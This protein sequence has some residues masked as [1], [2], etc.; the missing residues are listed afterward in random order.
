LRLH[1]SYCDAG[2]LNYQQNEFFSDE[3]LNIKVL[4]FMMQNKGV[5]ESEFTIRRL[6][7][8]VEPVK[9]QTRCLDVLEHFI[10]NESLS[11]IAIVD[12]KNKPLGLME[13]GRITE[14]FLKPF[15][16]D[17]FHKK[18]IDEIMDPEP[19]IV[20]IDSS[21]EDVVN[22]IINSGMHHMVNGVIVLEKGLYAG[23]ATGHAL[24]E[25][26]S[27]RRQ[28]D[29]YL[30]AHY[31]HLTGLP[32]RMLFNDRLLQACQNAKRNQKMLA[33]V[34]IDLDRFKFINDSMGHSFGDQIL[35]MVSE[36]LLACVRQSD[37][38]ARLG[39]DEFVM[40]LQNIW[41]E[42]DAALLIAEINHRMR[43]PMPV[44]GREIQITVSMGLAFYPQHDEN[45]DG[46]I[47]K[48]DA[49]MY[50][51]KERGRNDF[52]IFSEHMDQ[53]NMQRMSLE[54]QLRMALEGNEFF[55]CYQPQIKLPEKKII[56]VEALLRWSHPK[57]GMVSPGQFI[58]IAEETGLIV[59]IGEWVLREACRQHLHWRQQGMPPIRIA[60]NISAVQ[61]KQQ[62][63]C[64]MVNKILE[65][66]GMEPKYLELELTESAVMSNAEHAVQA[67]ADL[68]DLGVKLAIDDFGTGY[69]SLSY[70]RKFPIDRIKIDQSFIHQIHATSANEAIVRAIIALADSL[71]LET[72]AEGVEILEDLEC[73]QRYN[74]LEVQGY[75][76]A[77]PLDKHQF[78]V[79]CK[80]CFNP[81]Q[82][83]GKVS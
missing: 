69:S 22:I 15:A 70:L 19:I 60:V 26:I 34:F 1:N 5:D 36:R 76:F 31:D 27:Q 33:L 79:W 7:G 54:T 67:L 43:M 68:R 18:L 80:E 30:L 78:D 51:V 9:T 35:R 17:L 11:T 10:K 58:P 32:N 81:I 42:E 66:T 6:F 44:F 25:K 59:P 55:L 61:F 24:L 74:C 77:K 16:R 57:L 4:D 83:L 37:T 23:L 45:I 14:I 8:Y 38:V 56:G 41:T 3:F 63:F 64:S 73:I 39:G 52:M 82:A 71:G 40:I 65:Q 48:A 46:L 13:R 47:R 29:L 75:L 21:I 28:H 62:N 12:E 50:E 53:S 20:D 2:F 72:L 49:A